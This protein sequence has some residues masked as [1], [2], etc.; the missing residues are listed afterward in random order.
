MDN[1]VVDEIR[2][3]EQTADSALGK[4]NLVAKSLTKY[5]KKHLAVNQV[6]FSE[7]NINSMILCF[8]I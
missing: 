1:D 3:V 5:Y 8:S 7:Y 6:S 4:R 2:H